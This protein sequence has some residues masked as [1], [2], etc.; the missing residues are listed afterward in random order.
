MNYTIAIVQL[1]MVREPGHQA[2]MTPAEAYRVCSDMAG[3]AQECL[4]VLSLNGMNM[5]IN[6]HMVS[7]GSVNSCPVHPLEVFRPAIIDGATA[8]VIVHNHVSGEVTPSAEDLN[9]TKM[10][11]QAGRILKIKVLDHVIIGRPSQGDGDKAP[12]PAFMSLR[13]N[14]ICEF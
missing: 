8:I 9:I 10:I 2:V 5:L 14:G 1:P 6:R 13:E 11:V 12:T 7:L 3:L 4:H